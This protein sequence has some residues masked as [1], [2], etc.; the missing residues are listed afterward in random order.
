MRSVATADDYATTSDVLLEVIGQYEKRATSFDDMCCIYPA[1][2]FVTGEK[3]VKEM[4]LLNMTGADTVIPVTAFSYS[5]QR[6]MIIN[7][8]YIEIK[9]SEYMH[10]RSQDSEKCTMT[11]DNSIVQ[12]RQF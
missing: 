9:Y 3:L 6:G 8:K 12:R 10:S 11:A 7:G 1:A 4:E 2:P 5:L